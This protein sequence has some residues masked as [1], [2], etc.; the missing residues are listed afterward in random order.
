MDR[1]IRSL[2]LAIQNE[3]EQMKIQNRLLA[4]DVKESKRSA[5]SAVR[6]A[7]AAWELVIMTREQI[8][9]D[10]AYLKKPL[11]KKWFTID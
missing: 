2:T 8:K 5:D 1:D 6:K 9:E 4:K 10:L 7:D 3:V 11:W